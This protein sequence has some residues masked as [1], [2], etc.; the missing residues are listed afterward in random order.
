VL[1]NI[2]KL[3]TVPQKLNQAGVTLIELLV[4]IG[5]SSALF[6]SFTTV[7]VYLY[8]D[9][10][11]SSLYA[12]LATESQSVL[13]SIVEE[14]R[15]SSSI[16]TS[17][18]NTDLNAPGGGWTTSNS[19]LILIISTPVLNSSNQFIINPATGDPYQNE[20]V[21]FNSNG[22]L[23]KRYIADSAAS[24]NTRKTTCPQASSSSTCPADVL[25]TSNFKTMSFTF[26]DQDDV[27]TN[28]IPDARSIKLNVNMERKSF[29][30]TLTFNNTMRITIRNTYP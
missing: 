23:Y 5:V 20:I 10:V 11:R 14:L 25:L 13:R 29:G 1:G 22:K 17:N 8:G 27:V 2:K 16:R 9:T 6:V 15:Q 4:V 21:Y 19:N 18:A 3:V 12:Q 26:Y 28:N 7:S 24:G 30:K